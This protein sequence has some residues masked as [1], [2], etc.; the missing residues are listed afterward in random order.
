ME[1]NLKGVTMRKVFWGAAD[2]V[3]VTQGASAR[4][5][6]VLKRSA[7]IAQAVHTNAASGVYETG[8]DLVQK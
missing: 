3:P 1:T 7:G 5:S 8:T 2:A 4:V 6:A